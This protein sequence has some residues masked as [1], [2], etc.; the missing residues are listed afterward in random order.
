MPSRN[1]RFHLGRFLLLALGVGLAGWAAGIPF[2]VLG[3]AAAVYLSWQA[4]NLWRLY[5]WVR[6]PVSDIPR[7]YG[8]WSDIFGEIGAL[9][10]RN[11]RQ[12]KK[13]R[14]TI[15]DLRN[16]VQ[17][18]PDASLVID[19]NDAV[20]WF[21]TAAEQLLDLKNP[22]DLGRPLTNLL[23]G[24]DLS[25]WLAG[26]EA[27]NPLEMP[28]P[29]GDRRWLTVNVVA[30]SDLQRLVVL[31]DTTEVHSLDKIRRDFVANISHEL[32]TPL[33]V[34]QG[35]LELLEDH[36]SGDTSTAVSTM[37]QQSGHMQSLLDDL[38][39]L[40]R[41]QSGELQ[42]D[43]EVVDIGA[44]LLRLKEQAEALSRGRHEILLEI[45][46]G[47]FLAGV[48]ADLESSFG[49]LISNAVKYSP[50][51]GAITIRWE[52]RAGAP[53]LSVSDEGIGI[54]TRD[55]PRLTERFYRVGSDRGRQSG[56][57]GLGLAI[58][59][60]VL[61]AH[62]AELL[63]QSVFGKGSTFTASF[64]PERMRRDTDD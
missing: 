29:R 17:A 63:V 50:D 24:P 42:G 11:R 34:I 52:E 49:N 53:R 15:D 37:L 57:T 58:V 21:N 45:D 13:Y 3:A 35:Y 12:K 14:S 28:S 23:R 4:A 9:Q 51:K 25:G 32:R 18:F 48:T 20:N 44:M 60:H 39:E 2:V 41:V 30:L 47:L 19:E 7:S 33:T 55:I 26:S 38:L 62:Q 10:T 61:N 31:R 46:H 36:P 59:K 43:E 5:R 22:G 56:G 27:K 40:S 16:L 54:P 6:N 1:W 8:V 64:P